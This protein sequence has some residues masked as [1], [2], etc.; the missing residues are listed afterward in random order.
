ME[1][2]IWMIKILLIYRKRFLIKT[3]KKHTSQLSNKLSSMMIM[4]KLRHLK[5]LTLKLLKL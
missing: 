3:Y 5:E 2:A 4:M 1:M